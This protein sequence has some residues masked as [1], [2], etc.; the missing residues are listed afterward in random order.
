MKIFATSCLFLFSYILPAQT[1]IRFGIEAGSNITLPY[2]GTNFSQTNS[3]SA[4]SFWGGALIESSLNRSDNFFRLQLEVLYNHQ[5]QKINPKGDYY[6]MKFSQISMPL[7]GKL[8]FSKHTSLDF[9][10]IFNFN[11]SAHQ[12]INFENSIK[13]STI[14]K[15]YLS[16]VQ[17]GLS[18]RLNYY[19]TNGFFIT[20]RYNPMFGYAV[21]SDN[22]NSYPFRPRLSYAQIGIG[23]LFHSFSPEVQDSGD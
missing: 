21:Q 14:K 12:K 18:A 11:I 19:F 23:F 17:V 22:E 5:Y 3:S 9:G 8:F 2:A 20:A 7:T 16:S 15:G 13:D 10:P 6:W 4:Y 1:T